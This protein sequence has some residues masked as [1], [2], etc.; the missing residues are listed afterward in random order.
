MWRF[1]GFSQGHIYGLF[2]QDT[3]PILQLGWSGS[4]QNHI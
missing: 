3:R 4:F 1:S 2:E